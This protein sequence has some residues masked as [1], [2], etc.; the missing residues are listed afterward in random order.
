M[1]TGNETTYQAPNDHLGTEVSRDCEH[2]HPNV[3]EDDSLCRDW[4]R[5]NTVSNL[6]RE[7]GSEGGTPAIKEIVLI[8]CCTVTCVTGERLR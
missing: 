3:Q 7:G 8:V 2:L 4:E 6:L 5:D 1:E